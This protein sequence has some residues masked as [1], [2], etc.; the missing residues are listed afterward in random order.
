MA[1][2]LVTPRA[3][4][5]RQDCSGALRGRRSRCYSSK[6][7]IFGHLRCLHRFILTGHPLLA[8]ANGTIPAPSLLKQIIVGGPNDA[9]D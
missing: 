4:R 1:E 9:L 3:S 8:Q 2:G 5:V 6:G 7:L